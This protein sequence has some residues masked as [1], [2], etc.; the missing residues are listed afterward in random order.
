MGDNGITIGLTKSLTSNY[1]IS[2]GIRMEFEWDDLP[3]S[4]LIYLWIMA[5]LYFIYL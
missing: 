5:H 1:G 4:S 2:M 3:S